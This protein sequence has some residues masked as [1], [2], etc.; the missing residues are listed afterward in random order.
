MTGTPPG[1]MCTGSSRARCFRLPQ[2]RYSGRLADLGAGSL[3]LTVG[4]DFVKTPALHRE[5]SLTWGMAR[6]HTQGM[7]P[8]RTPA[9]RTVLAYDTAAFT[10]TMSCL[11]S[12]KAPI[13]AA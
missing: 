4:E 5:G 9:L 2:G 3:G 6:N 1:E 8:A 11:S 12:I 7:N 13:L 10:I